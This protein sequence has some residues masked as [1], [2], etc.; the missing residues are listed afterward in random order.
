MQ[1]CE[2]R[3]FYADPKEY[4]DI[5][6]SQILLTR[7]E[8]Y[9]LES[10]DIWGFFQHKFSRIG[11]LAKYRPFFEKLLRSNIEACIEQNIFLCELRH[12]TGCLYDKS[13]EANPDGP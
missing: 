5:L 11:G 9:G 13:G 8:Q 1:C 10:H 4:D 6:K 3:S 12:T 2:M 7:E